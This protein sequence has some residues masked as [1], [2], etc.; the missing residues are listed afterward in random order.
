MYLWN[1]TLRQMISEIDTF[2]YPVTP[3]TRPSIFFKFLVLAGFFT[4]WRSF[5]WRGSNNK[6]FAQFFFKFHR[7]KKLNETEKVDGKEKLLAFPSKVLLLLQR[8]VANHLW[9]FDYKYWAENICQNSNYM[10]Q[11]QSNQIKSMNLILQ[12]ND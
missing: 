3:F 2:G 6:Y 4:F 10:D 8:D 5:I 11:N 12:I 9:F 7:R 1:N